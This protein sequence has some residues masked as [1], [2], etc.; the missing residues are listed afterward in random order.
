[1]EP[2]SINP[3]AAAIGSQL[4]DVASRALGAGAAALPSLTG[5]APAGAEEVSLQ[6]VMAFAAEAEAL[7]A[8]NTAAQEELARAGLAVTEIAQMYSQVDGEAAGTLMA[9]GARF[10]S[11]AF[12]GGT[13][14]AGA[15][16]AASGLLRAETLPVAGGAPARSPSMANLIGGV[17]ASN[18]S[19]TVPAAAQAASTVLGAGTAPLSSMGQ[20]TSAG[21]AA[22]GA[23]TAA[24][25]AS[26]TGEEESTREHPDDQQADGQ[27]P[28]EEL[29]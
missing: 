29:V 22:A 18:P 25:P 10:S 1:M 7:L 27:Q 16:N 2:M 24:T 21:G 17:A 4:V 13:G 5:L 28:G 8:L 23:P 15:P 12:A 3:A 6:A 14:A 20:F 19:T 9:G 26:L 11:Q